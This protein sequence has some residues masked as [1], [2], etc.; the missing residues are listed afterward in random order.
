MANK[1]SKPI[2]IEYIIGID[3]FGVPIYHRH[4]LDGK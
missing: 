3:I 2:V 4:Y 1:K